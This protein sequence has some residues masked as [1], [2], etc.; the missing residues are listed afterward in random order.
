MLLILTASLVRLFVCTVRREDAPVKYLKPGQMWEAV[1]G[2]L[3]LQVSRPS[4]TTWLKDT[5]GLSLDDNKMVVGAPSPFVAQWLEQR[6]SSL[7]EA[8]LSQ[9]AGAPTTVRFQVVTEPSAHTA[10]QML[11]QTSADRI[12]QTVNGRAASNEPRSIKLNPRYTLDSFVVGESNQLAYAAAMA[13]SSRPG[14]AY[15]PLFLYGGV[16]LGKTH[17]LHG[18]GHASAGMGL[19][20]LYVSSEQFTNEFITSI[21]LKRTGEFREKYRSVDVLLM[22]DIQFLRGKEAIQEGF[23]H[24]FN[25]LHNSNRQ[26]VI[27]CDRPSSE[28]VPLEDRL[29]SRFQW[30]LSADIR[31][32]DIETRKAILEVKASSM[33][34]GVPDEVLDLISEHC[35]SSI[36]EL[37]GALNR[38][39]AYADLTAQPLCLDL[40]YHSLGDLL[41]TKQ[42]QRP[43]AEVVISRVCSFYNI[44]TQAL[45]SKRRDKKVTLARQVAIY[46]LREWVNMSLKDIGF[47]VGNRDH[48]T[49]R[50]AWAKILEAKGNDR[51]LKAQLASLYEDIGDYIL[52]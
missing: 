35:L 42:K 49:V 25:D 50:H 51:S 19:N 20:Y 21:Q 11:P 26:I 2:S 41:T 24:T 8:A 14:S 44:E 27:A 10:R 4:Y 48:T 17:L 40:A 45:T 12:P 29:R 32:P 23:F 37:E 1:L 36:R 46:L 43:S 16:G 33:G 7:V 39:C 47:L 5:V 38:V 13:V 30:G 31:M 18:I 9:V 28:L 3:E 15:N 52:E 6:M 34:I 22:D